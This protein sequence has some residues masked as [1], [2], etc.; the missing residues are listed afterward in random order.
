VRLELREKSTSNRVS[1]DQSS[2]RVGFDEIEGILEDY[3]RKMRDAENED[4]EGKRK[5]ESIW[6][7]LRVH[8]SRTRYIYELY[9]KRDAISKELYDWLLKEDYADKKWVTF[10]NPVFLSFSFCFLTCNT[11]LIAKWK[12]PGYEKLCCSRC[13]QTKVRRSL[14]LGS[15]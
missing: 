3:Q 11:S 6:P 1:H 15:L 5:N 10:A 8:H 4:H 14:G 7:I 2:A 9:Y 12:K 13:I